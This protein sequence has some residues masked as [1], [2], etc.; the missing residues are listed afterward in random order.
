[1]NEPCRVDQDR[2]VCQNETVCYLN[3]TPPKYVRKYIKK[4]PEQY[5]EK[6]W[7]LSVKYRTSP[8]N[9]VQRHA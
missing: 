6:L 7:D 2:L 4:Q 8:W 9:A 5:W 1:M 3:V